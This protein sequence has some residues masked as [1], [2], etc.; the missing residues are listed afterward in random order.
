MKRTLLIICAFTAISVLFSC[1]PKDSEISGFEGFSFAFLPDIHLQPE[2][3]AV[4][5]FRAAI[6]KVNA[7][8]PDF[9]IAGGDMIMDALGV[10]YERADSLY[11]MYIEES[12]AFNMPVYNTPGN[13]EFFGVY[14][15]SG[16]SP[17]HEE[18]GAAM[19]QNRLGDLYYSFDHKGWHFM[20]LNSV[21]I[22]DEN[23]YIGMIDAEQLDWIRNDLAGVDSITPIVISTHIPFITVFTQY[24]Y[25]NY[26]PDYHGLVVENAREVLDLFAGHN[27]K[28]VLQGHL[29]FYENIEVNG[30]NFITAGAVSGKWWQ[31]ASHDVE[32][33]FLM[34]Y[35]RGDKIFPRY[36]D[37]DW[38]VE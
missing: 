7:G 21:Q 22:T 6:E 14:E 38:E 33:G 5:G 35:I 26:A 37:Y 24:L 9:V 31:G 23:R 28:L 36:V 13:H 2:R 25:G 29:H 19:Y 11:T 20:V 4:D 30:I 18:Y 32:E 34:V 12:E 27:L 17:D 3:N 15:K 8:K 10:S 1:I 16:V